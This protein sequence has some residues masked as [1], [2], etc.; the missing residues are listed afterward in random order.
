VR[1]RATHGLDHYDAA[2]PW[3][4]EPASAARAE[5]ARIRF[6]RMVSR[7]GMMSDLE[8]TA[9]R[10]VVFNLLRTNNSLQL[11]AF[12]TRAN[13]EKTTFRVRLRLPAGAVPG[14]VNLHTLLDDQVTVIS[15]VV[16]DGWLVFDLPLRLFALAEIRMN[17]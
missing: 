14:G 11:R 7:A 15:G 9:D 6:S 5:K 13:G 1:N 17:W 12:D 10:E 8:S 4:K 3:E 16:E 2:S